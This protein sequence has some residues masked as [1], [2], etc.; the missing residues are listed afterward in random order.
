MH[1][2]DLPFTRCSAPIHLRFSRINPI[3]S[4]EIYPILLHQKLLQAHILQV[5]PLNRNLR[6]TYPR[7]LPI[8]TSISICIVFLLILLQGPKKEPIFKLFLAV[9]EDLLETLGDSVADP[10]E[11]LGLLD[12]KHGH[13]VFSKCINDPLIAESL[14]FHP[15][16]VR[17]SLQFEEFIAV[18]LVQWIQSLCICGA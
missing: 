14:I 9:T 16:H 18:K 15:A 2:A 4:R 8:K 3:F 17:I 11:K 6:Q 13:G 5:L 10:F 1:I 12:A 7:K